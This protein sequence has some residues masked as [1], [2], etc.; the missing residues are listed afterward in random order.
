[1]VRRPAA[2]LTG[3]AGFWLVAGAIA[4]F[5]AASSAPSP[6]YVVYQARWHFSAVTLTVIFAIYAL[7]LLVTL[8]CVGGLS[9][10]VGR[11][12]VLVGALVLEVLAMAAFLAAGGVTGLVLARVVQGV[13]TGAAAG[14]LSATLVDLQPGG[15]AGLAAAVNAAAPP[16]GLAAGALLSGAL[17]QHAPA[18]TTLV[19]AVLAVVFVLLL[20][21]VAL[22]PEPVSRR[23]GA[24]ASL[25]PRVT[26][27]AAARPAL[28]AAA[29]VLISTW[30]VGGLVLSLGPSLAA[31]VLGVHDHLVGG[32]VVT[33]MTGCSAVASLGVRQ[34]EPRAT[35][36]GGSL[37][38]AVGVAVVLVAL[39]TGS[40][41]VFF[42]SLAVTGVGFGT[43]FV[44]AFGSVASLA[45]PHQRAE[46]FAALYVL[47]Y[48]AFGLP[49]VL[50]G[51]AVP[52]LGLRP[53][54][55]AYGAVVIALSLLACGLGRRAWSGAP[56]VSR[57]G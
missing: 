23:A 43:A 42:V 53:T 6:L 7:A 13:A 40:L 9:D 52:S 48:V 24:V 10:W 29:P 54:A 56:A 3:G 16:A 21:S 44:G 4:A 17:V 39:G 2:R 49:A 35:M 30:A 37:V 36:V 1:M 14:V 12:P 8:L 31:G 41:A 28:R 55:T 27:P 15:R 22:L 25:R 11:R 5:F 51:L 38:L 32:L 19:Y 57:S 34:R 33:A 47:S 26:V 46:L 50:A 20:V 45:G 18:P